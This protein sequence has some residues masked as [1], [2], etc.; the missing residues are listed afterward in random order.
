MVL[1]MGKKTMSDQIRV[2]RRIIQALNEIQETLLL[3]LL[4]EDK[5]FTG[6]ISIEVNC[7]QGGITGTEVFS[8]RKLKVPIDK[9]LD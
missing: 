8:K 5:S 4:E 9:P 2:K 7:N 1:R 6:K 3:L